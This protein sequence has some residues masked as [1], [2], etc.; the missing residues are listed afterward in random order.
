MAAL[1]LLPSTVVFCK[2]CGS[3]AHTS[4]IR[5]VSIEGKRKICEFQEIGVFKRGV[6]G[7]KVSEL[8]LTDSEL[9]L[10]SV[11]HDAPGGVSSWYGSMLC[12]D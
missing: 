11:V 4:E 12:K 5:W 3:T 2:Q 7:R 9:V 8:I 6:L 1:T 10:G